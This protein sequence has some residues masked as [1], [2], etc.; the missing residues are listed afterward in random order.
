MPA[1]VWG[2]GPCVGMMSRDSHAP[3]ASRRGSKAFLRLAAAARVAGVVAA[4]VALVALAEEGARWRI[5]PARGRRRAR[6]WPH[7]R[8]LPRRLHA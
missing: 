5:L 8:L 2:A 4:L 6:A 3:N 7:R 1:I